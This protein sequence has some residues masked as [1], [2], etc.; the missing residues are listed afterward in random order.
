[1]TTSPTPG[2]NGVAVRRPKP[3]AANAFA[4]AARAEHSLRAFLDGPHRYPLSTMNRAELEGLAID[5]RGS[6]M[7]STW[8]VRN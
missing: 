6:P 8:I 7:R 4:G 3:G 1:M 5:L 2:S